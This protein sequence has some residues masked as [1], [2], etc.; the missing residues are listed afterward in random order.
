MILKIA[1]GKPSKAFVAG[2]APH[3]SREIRFETARVT[4]LSGLDIEEKEIRAILE[5]LGVNAEV[6]VA[7]SSS[8]AIK[9]RLKTQTAEAEARGLFGAPS[10]TIGDELF[11]GNDRLEAALAWAKRHA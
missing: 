8:P 1:G 6:A 3:L 10:F 9:E 11:W 4:K 5:G 7:T 2:K